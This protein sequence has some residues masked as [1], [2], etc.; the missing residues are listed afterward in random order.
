MFFFFLISIFSNF[1]FVQQCRM[2]MTGWDR[3]S[4]E[5]KKRVRSK[6]YLQR[7]RWAITCWINLMWISNDIRGTILEQEHHSG[8]LIACISIV[9]RY[10]CDHRVW[11]GSEVISQHTVYKHSAWSFKQNGKLGIM[12]GNNG[13]G[14][15]ESKKMF[16]RI[17]SKNRTGLQICQ[18]WSH[19]LQQKHAIF[20]GISY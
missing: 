20:V 17:T 10:T 9:I 16:H 19:S 5:R 4:G 13:Q 6:L 15:P 3:Q 8:A 7:R 14:T 11:E 1:H 2:C 12:S 18:A